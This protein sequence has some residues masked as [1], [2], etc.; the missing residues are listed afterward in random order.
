MNCTLFLRLLILC[1]ALAASL[2]A[3]A[4]GRPYAAYHLENLATAAHTPEQKEAHLAQLNGIGLNARSHEELQRATAVLRSCKDTAPTQLTAFAAQTAVVARLFYNDR[5]PTRKFTD[6]SWLTPELAGELATV[7]EQSHQRL[8]I[9]QPDLATVMVW[10]RTGITLDRAPEIET[11]VVRSQ[12]DARLT[13]L[14]RADTATRYAICDYARSLEHRDGR[15]NLAQHLLYE[16][17]TPA[18]AA[19]SAA[20]DAL[21]FVAFMPAHLVSYAFFG[22]AFRLN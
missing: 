6:R 9:Q 21:A 17:T 20:S 14:M 1:I 10:T 16:P 15:Y 18:G 22:Q 8:Q 12:N 7:F 19:A 4:C 2:L 3:T 11:L 13:C 5:S